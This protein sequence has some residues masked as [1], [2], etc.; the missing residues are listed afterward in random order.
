MWRDNGELVALTGTTAPLRW[1]GQVRS[2]LMVELLEH[3]WSGRVRVQ[4][5]DQAQELDLY[6]ATARS[7]MVT[8]APPPSL[9]TRAAGGL[10][11]ADI[12]SCGVLLTAALL[13]LATWR[14]QARSRVLPW[15]WYTLPCVVVW[16]CT[17]LVFF[18]GLMSS[19]SLD[20]WDQ[21]LRGKYNDVHPAFHTLTMW[22]ITR[23]WLSPAAVA[24]A[25]I[26]ALALVCGLTVRELALLGVSRWVQVVLIVLF[27]LSPV[28][29][30]MVI[31]LWKD[32]PYAIALLCVF[33]MLLRVWRTDG[34][35][36]RARM[37]PVA[38][39]AALA[40]L[41]L[42][43][44]NG[45]PTALLILPAL[46]L[47]GRQA[48]WRQVVV[49]GGVS[50]ALVLLVKVGLYR[51][52]D[53]ASA[54]PWFA[55][56]MQIHQLGAFVVHSEQLDGSDRALLERLLP[57]DEWHRR[58]WCYSLNSLLYGDP[59]PDQ[60][61]FDTNVGEFTAL[62]QKLALRDPAT[63]ARHQWCLTN[64]IWRVTQSEEAYLST[65]PRD[66]L[67]QSQWA[68]LLGVGPA[69]IVPSVRDQWIVPW[70]ERLEQPEWVWLVWRPA[71]YLYLALFCVAVA[72]IRHR[73]WRLAGLALPVVAQSLIWMLLLTV[74]DFR[75]QYGTYVI[76]LLALGLVFLPVPMRGDA[77]CDGGVVPS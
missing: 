11:L 63:L 20:Q 27:A 41:A 75:F 56:Q 7:R 42:Y 12:I 25:Q 2:A 17:L 1:R 16:S 69:S 28:N 68:H 3:P 52:L 44:H 8:L 55:R 72:M 67:I 35:W 76:G 22:L 47:V 4:V 30:L 36:L 6:A 26:G 10:W 74:Q 38:I 39:G 21:M 59:L 40:A 57:R 32:I 14:P 46:L 29:N 43:R 9:W 49:I 33:W 48:R 77:E 64:L 19:D 53:V 66:L 60:H 18:P 37:A 58:Y 31:T 73:S 15:F 34:V 54:P 65:W 51:A 13:L 62:W 23:V 61:L 24:L 50:V 45:A 5:G 70:L 71:L